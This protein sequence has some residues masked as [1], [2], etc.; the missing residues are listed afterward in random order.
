M[1]KKKSSFDIF[2]ICSGK[3]IKIMDMIE[4]IKKYTRKKIKISYKKKQIGD[5]IDTYGNNNKL[6]NYTKFKKN[7]I[8]L[9][10]VLKIFCKLV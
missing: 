1:K 10:L 5:M 7:F 3:K 2:N 6:K 4:L 9:I 8:I